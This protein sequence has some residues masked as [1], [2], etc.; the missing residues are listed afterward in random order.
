MPLI[1]SRIIWGTGSLVLILTF[2]SGHMWNKIKNAPYVQA[3][4]GGKMTWIAGGFQNQLGME[5]QVIGGI[6]KSFT[7]AYGREG[8]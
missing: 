8:V 7:S 6:C 4:E 3:G 1:Q 5:S 2:T